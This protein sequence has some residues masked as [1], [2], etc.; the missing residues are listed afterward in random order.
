M[1]QLLV[2]EEFHQPGLRE[3]RMACHGG[4]YGGAWVVGEPFRG[5]RG[6]LGV[7]GGQGSDF[8]V[9][10]VRVAGQSGGREIRAG[11]ELLAA[12][13]GVLQEAAQQK[14][15]RGVRMVLGQQDVYAE[16]VVLGPPGHEVGRQRVVDGRFP[17]Q[18]R[19]AGNAS[20]RTFSGSR[21][22]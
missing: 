11:G 17:P 9:L 10:V 5:R 18:H 1:G 12:V 6:G 4:P 2:V 7:A 19:V 16:I 22:A 21:R 3:P 20:R 15:R 8:G 14:P 13:A